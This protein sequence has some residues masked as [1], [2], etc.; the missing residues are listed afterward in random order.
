MELKKR[1]E[2]MGLET[3]NGC[4]KKKNDQKLETRNAQDEKTGRWGFY[5]CVKDK[6]NY[7]INKSGMHQAYVS[8]KQRN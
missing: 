2:W 5:V 3:R 4:R 8:N 6:K 7:C 1:G